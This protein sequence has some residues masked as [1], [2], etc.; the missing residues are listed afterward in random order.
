LFYNVTFTIPS[1]FCAAG[2]SLT[3]R[4]AN[5]TRFLAARRRLQQMNNIN[6]GTAMTM[7]SS[8]TSNAVSVAVSVVEPADEETA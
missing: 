7:S 8:T 1:F 6:V 3:V 5:A 2:A 4:A